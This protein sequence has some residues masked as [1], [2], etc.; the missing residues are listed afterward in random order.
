LWVTTTCAKPS[1]WRRPWEGRHR[2]F[3][4]LLQRNLLLPRIKVLGFAFWVL[5]DPGVTC[6]RKT[7]NL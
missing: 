6:V 2:P 5:G 7:Q 1:D 4:A 3:S